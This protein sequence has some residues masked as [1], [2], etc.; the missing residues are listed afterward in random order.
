MSSSY[1]KISS[2]AS[3]FDPYGKNNKYLQGTKNFLQSN[4]IVAKIAFIILV[5]FI[6]VLLLRLGTSVL[7][8]I[9]TFSSSPVLVNGM[10]NGQRLVVIPQNPNI[11]N[12]IPILRSKDQTDG[13]VFTWSTW[14]YINQPGLANHGCTNCPTAQSGHYRHVF[15]KGSDTTGPDGV[16]SPNNA[17]GLYISPDYRNLT[18]IMSTFDNP[19]EEVVIGDLPIEH[20]LNVIVRQD[21]HRMD[22][23]ING[24]LTRSAILKGVPNQNYDDVYVGLNGGFSGNI[25]QLQYFAYAI[26]ANK[27]QEI[28]D[29][30]PNLKSLEAKSG[31]VDANYLSFRWFFPQQSDE[32]Q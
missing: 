25:S 23:F 11:S 27:I 31:D 28:V 15:S 10:M 20:W 24:T 13:L 21:Q 14:L 18:V 7:A 26:G 19:R 2:G 32:M 8:S 29:T 30:G 17:P 3:G 6:F 16:M 5:I 22:V 9:F 4:S 12:A 1:R